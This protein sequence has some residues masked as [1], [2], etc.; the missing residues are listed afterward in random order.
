MNSQA[1]LKNNYDNKK[2]ME[3]VHHISKI[4]NYV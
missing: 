1:L 4:I 2:G 3:G